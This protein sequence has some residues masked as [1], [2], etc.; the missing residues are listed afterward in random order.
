MKFEN[1]RISNGLIAEFDDFLEYEDSSE[2]FA[3]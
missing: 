2:V 3:A 1:Q